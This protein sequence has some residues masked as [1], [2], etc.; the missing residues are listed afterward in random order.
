LP[1]I[2]ISLAEG[3]AWWLVRLMEGQPNR[4]LLIGR[5]Q[6]VFGDDLPGMVGPIACA[7]IGAVLSAVMANFT[8]P[9]RSR[10][11][12]LTGDD[13]RRKVGKDGRYARAEGM[14]EERAIH[15]RAESRIDSILGL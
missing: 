1:V 3:G 9:R 14:V 2:L 15:A 8:D 13:L 10:R 7:F 4:E 11:M 5:I 12:V 6:A